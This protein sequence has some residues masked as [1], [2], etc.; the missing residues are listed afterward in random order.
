VATQRRRPIEAEELIEW[1][2]QTSRFRPGWRLRLSS[3]E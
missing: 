3:T 2:Q 1:V